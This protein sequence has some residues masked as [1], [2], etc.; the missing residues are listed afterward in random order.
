MRIKEI[1]IYAV[2]LPVANGPYVM[3]GA[4]VSKLD[5]TVVELVTDSGLIGFGETCPVGPTYQQEHALGARAALTQMCDALI[6]RNPLEIESV[7][8]TMDA[9][10]NGHNYAKAAIDIAPVSYTHLTLPTIPL[11]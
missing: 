2:D 4:L 5:S 11:V 9:Q 1:H 7:R 3:S 8:N 6:G 10:L